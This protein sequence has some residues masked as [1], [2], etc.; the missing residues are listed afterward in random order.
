VNRAD[1]PTPGTTDPSAAELRE[2]D[3]M[4]ALRD[5]GLLDHAVDPEFDRLTNL[6]AKLLKVPTALISLVDENRQF[7]LSAFGLGQPWAKKR[8]TPITHSFCKVA[9]T[10]N[11]P[12]VVDNAKLDPRVRENL[13]VR[14]LGVM[15]YAGIPLLSAAQP[16]GALC[17]IEQQPRTWTSDEV[18]LLTELAH[19]VEKRLEL[20]RTNTKLRA[21]NV[22]IREQANLYARA[23][24]RLP[25]AA[26]MIFDRDLRYVAADGPALSPN[27]FQP[28]QMVGRHLTEVHSPRNAVRLETLYRNALSGQTGEGEFD[29]RGRRLSLHVLPLRDAEGRVDR[30]MVALYDITARHRENVILRTL[31]RSLPNTAVAIFDPELRYVFADG[32]LLKEVTGYSPEQMKGKSL[33]AALQP[34][35]AGETRGIELYRAAL[36][37]EPKHRE[38]HRNGRIYD[39]HIVP[40]RDD[41]GAIV[42]GMGLIY[43]ITDRKREAEA[44]NAAHAQLQKQAAQ[45]EHLSI[46]DEL[47]QLYNRRGFMVLAEQSLRQA[48]RREAPLQLF[49]LDLNGLKRINDQIGHEVGDRAIQAMAD[50]L[51]GSFREVDVLARLGGDEFAVLVN[52]AGAEASEVLRGRVHANVDQWNATHAAPFTLSVS[53]GVV[54]HAPGAASTLDGLLSQADALMYEQKRGRA[55]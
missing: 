16:I 11:A 2:R 37:G 14:D 36:A 48:K 20:H 17:V 22:R 21:A 29:R 30:G 34:Q 40:V 32:P 38:L 31:A 4:Q 27:G 28:E 52:D 8:E 35:S 51:R 1:G 13:A 6:V 3:R 43:D 5:T 41:D 54:A 7:F 53:I 46:T 24:A 10:A 50:V 49:Y 9:V 42:A 33:D 55:R 44:L 19:T 39:H 18:E 15:A 45:L 47:T 12:L 26:V 23:L 25:D